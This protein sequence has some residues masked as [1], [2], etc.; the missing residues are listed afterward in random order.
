MKKLVAELDGSGAPTG[1]FVPQDASIVDLI[2][3]TQALDSSTGALRA[4]GY[5]VLGTLLS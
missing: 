5:L 2:N 1:K 4:I 3:P